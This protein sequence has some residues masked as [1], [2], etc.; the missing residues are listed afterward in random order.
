MKPEEAITAVTMLVVGKAV[1]QVGLKQSPSLR[2]TFDDIFRD[3]YDVVTL[4]ALAH[5]AVSDT[6]RGVEAPAKEDLL[7]ARQA[8]D[9][10]LQG[11]LRGVGLQAALRFPRR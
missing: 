7:R 1:Y 4:Y 2:L 5:N 6:L 10:A 11:R 3:D 9:K 8:G